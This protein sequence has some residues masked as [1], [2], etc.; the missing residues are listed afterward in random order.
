MPRECSSSQTI[1]SLWELRG[2]FCLRFRY[3]RTPN[4][5]AR[6]PPIK[7]NV[8]GSGAAAVAPARAG[9]AA[10]VNKTQPQSIDDTLFFNFASVLS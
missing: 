8:L 5:T 7:R 3:S 6:P 10:A 4:T 2:Y 9:M 1:K